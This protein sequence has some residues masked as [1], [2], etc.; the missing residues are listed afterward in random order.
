MASASLFY[1]DWVEEIDE[2]YRQLKA[3]RA[4]LVAH[5]VVARAVDPQPGMHRQLARAPDLV[6]RAGGEEKIED[7]PHEKDRYREIT[8]QAS[9]H[10][11][12]EKVR[13]TPAERLLCARGAITRPIAPARS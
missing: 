3:Y 10:K 11:R 12:S 6:E 1:A 4:R 8:G 13:V 2:R 7:R 9:L 5:P